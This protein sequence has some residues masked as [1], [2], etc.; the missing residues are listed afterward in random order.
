MLLP[1][2]DKQTEEFI[3]QH[4][5]LNLAEVALKLDKRKDLP[6]S[7]VLNQING[8]RKFKQKF[9]FL[10]DIEGFIFPSPTSFSQASSEI[11]AD[12][13]SKIQKGDKILDLGGGMG[14]DSC[15]FANHFQEVDFVEHNEELFHISRH[16]FAVL[17][18]SNVYTHY[19]DGIDFLK[20]TKNIYDLIYIDPDRRSKKNKAFKVED[21]EP[22]VLE[23]LEDLFK[24]SNKLLIKFSPMLDI[25]SG[26]SQLRHIKE[27]H[28]LSINNEC[29]ELLYLLD[30][31]YTS[32]AV[33]KCINIAN[34]HSQA[35]EF[36]RSNESN[37]KVNYSVPLKFLYEPNASIL[38]AGAFNTIASRFDLFKIAPNTHLYT[39]D[40][41]II[42]FPGKVF[43]I[44]S[45]NKA[46]KGVIKQANIISR[47]YPYTP[48]EIYKKY[49][50][51]SGGEIFIYACSLMDNSKKWI[52]AK[53]INI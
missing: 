26:I 16:N 20:K 43:E 51:K 25:F 50:I 29:K 14:M 21:C 28:V 32:E 5:H 46:S 22:N 47:N 24:R 34:K 40:N 4:L 44:L 17:N 9:P 42:N 18:K 11:A 15:F 8:K 36:L 12:Y 10:S 53:K 13:K 3:E 37:H 48:E 19:E 31:E 23:I 49:K 7:F 30:K 33:I 41:P 27:V 35:F 39:S 1:E 6:K 2:N 45:T 52:I 38:K